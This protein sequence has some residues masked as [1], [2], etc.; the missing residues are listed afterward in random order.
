MAESPTSRSLKT[1]RNENWTAQVVERWNQFAKCRQDLFGFI[2]VV[3]IKADVPGVLAIQAT[4]YSNM[5]A[6]MTKILGNKNTGIWLK[7]GNGL[8]VWGWQK[9]KNKMVLTRKE[10][11]Y[12]AFSRFCPF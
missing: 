5:S 2:D 4:S 3:A 7:A 1:L 10:V 12:D 6:R 11:T 9:K 8:E